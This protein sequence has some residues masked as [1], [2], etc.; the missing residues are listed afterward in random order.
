M[1]VGQQLKALSD[2]WR[3]TLAA[4]RLIDGPLHLP[5]VFP[6]SIAC[7]E[8]GEGL[9]DILRDAFILGAGQFFDAL[10]V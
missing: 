7:L 2:R 10:T 4:P 6:A 8:L 1:S 3:S 9:L 5:V